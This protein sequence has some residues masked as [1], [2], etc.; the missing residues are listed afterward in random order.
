VAFSEKNLVSL[1]KVAVQ[2]N[3]S[4]IHIRT[5][6]SP[7]LRIRGDMIPVQT[8]NFS[9]EDV[10]DIAKILIGSTRSN[11]NISEI[12]ELDGAYAVEDLCRLR[13]NFFRYNQNIGII[14]RIINTKIPSISDLGLVPIVKDIANQRRGLILLTGATG[15]GKSTTLAAMI[16]QINEQRN[17]HI[18]TIEDPIEYLHTQKKAR[19]TQ[20][21]VGSD[22]ENFSGALRAALRQDPDVILIGEMRDPETIS[23]ALK[24]AE[25]GHVVFSTIHTTNAVASI[26]RIIAM[27]PPEEQED[28]RKRLAEN[29]YATISQRMLKTAKD[30]QVV[31]AQEVMITSP[32]IKECILGEEPLS[33][34]TAI[35]EENKGDGGNGSQSFDQHIFELYNQGRISKEVALEAV[36]SQ[37]DFI[38]KLTVD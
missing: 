10:E 4:D 17:C 8:K 6:E 28:V 15:S 12:N 16:N 3:A 11:F 2:H 7:C 37:S 30:R 31:I 24:A 18:I 26:G 36:S 38:Q 1:V 22:T 25:T 27:Y 9:F 35:I 34:I 20:R 5:G 14:L 23:I 21:E 33:R 32:G 19:I 13:F 29:L